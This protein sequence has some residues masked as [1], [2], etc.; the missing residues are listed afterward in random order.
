MDGPSPDHVLPHCFPIDDGRILAHVVGERHGGRELPDVLESDHQSLVQSIGYAVVLV[1]LPELQEF[2]SRL[3]IQHLPVGI[4]EGAGD[5]RA[6]SLVV[7]KV[8]GR[9]S[10][11]HPV[12]P[13]VG[14]FRAEIDDVIL[15]H[16]S[17]VGADPLALVVVGDD[18]DASAFGTVF[19]DVHVPLR[20]CSGRHAINSS[21]FFILSIFSLHSGAPKY[22]PISSH[23]FPCLRFLR[24]PS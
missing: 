18:A 16:A 24:I 4:P 21:P 10:D 13:L 15:Q 22:A 14:G 8:V 5:V 23:L 3:A 6:Q 11:V 1:D 9:R 7:D 19:P 2:R 12:L 17:A 20:Y